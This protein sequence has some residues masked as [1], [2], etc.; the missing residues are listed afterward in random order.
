[1]LLE[2]LRDF[3]LKGARERRLAG[4]ALFHDL[5]AWAR[6][7]LRDNRAVRH[8][9]Q[10]RYQR[11]FVDEFQDTDP[12]QA[13]IAFFL[14]AGG[15]DNRAVPPDWRDV[16]LVP[17]KLCLVGDPKQSIYR[18]RGADIAVYDDLLQR[19]RNVRELLTH[20]FRSVEPVLDWVNHHFTAQMR[21]DT[22]F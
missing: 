13:E 10:A 18:F 20:N 15:R 8:R 6:D 1:S 2:F 16:A 21:P 14:S 3:A 5:L 4:T 19:M 17:G 22:G 9:A 7:L 11:I 12:L